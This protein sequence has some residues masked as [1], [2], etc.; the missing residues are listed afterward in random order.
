MREV[1]FN[2]FEQNSLMKPCMEECKRDGMNFG[3]GVSIEDCSFWAGRFRSFLS[4]LPVVRILHASMDWAIPANISSF[5]FWQKIKW[6]G[7]S[8]LLCTSS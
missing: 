2:G 5:D 6:L 8:L 4:R 1:R 7:S 3:C